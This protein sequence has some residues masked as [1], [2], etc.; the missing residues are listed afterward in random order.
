MLDWSYLMEL[1]DI[2]EGK[3]EKRVVLAA[4]ELA[5]MFRT[6]DLQGWLYGA[7]IDSSELATALT[8]LSDL[9]GVARGDTRSSVYFGRSGLR[10]ESAVVTIPPELRRTVV[11]TLVGTSAE[12]SSYLNQYGEAS[13]TQTAAGVA[14]GMRDALEQGVNDVAEFVILPPD[15]A[16]FILPSSQEPA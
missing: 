16:L 7:G 3:R 4:A 2:E 1:C 15:P 9:L 14:H 6:L 5:H 8:P 12:H 10:T 11:R 13:V